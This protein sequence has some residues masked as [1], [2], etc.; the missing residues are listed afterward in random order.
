M[1]QYD[2]VS[3]FERSPVRGPSTLQRSARL[4][5][6][7]RVRDL[8]VLRSCVCCTYGMTLTLARTP[9]MFLVRSSGLC[10]FSCRGVGVVSGGSGARGTC[11]QM[12]CRCRPLLNH[13][14]H[15]AAASRARTHVSA[16]SAAAAW[17]ARTRSD[18]PSVVWMLCIWHDIDVGPDDVDVCAPVFS[19]M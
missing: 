18:G 14:P 5:H 1:L 15:A 2:G 4:L 19:C 7:M 6:D 12:F 17:H 16:L 10:E 3:V 11:P 8:T 9:W 13:T